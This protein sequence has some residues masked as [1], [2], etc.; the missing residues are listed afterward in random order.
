MA[1]WLGLL[2]LILDIVGVGLLIRDE[3]T[4]LAARVRQDSPQ[5]AGGWW[6]AIAFWLARHFGSANPQDQ[7]SYVGESLASRL[8]GF[9]LILLGFLA[10]AAGLVIYLVSE[11]R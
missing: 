1:P 9:I 6:R 4:P 7:E 3:L 10:Q 11:Q 5:A 2:G 8:C